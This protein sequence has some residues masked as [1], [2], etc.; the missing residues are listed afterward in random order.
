MAA[1]S[2][3]VPIWVMAIGLVLLGVLLFSVL[4]A[5]RRASSAPPV[6]SVDD[7]AVTRAQAVPQLVLPPVPPPVVALAP[8]AEP[9][10]APVPRYVAPPQPHIVYMPQPTLPVTPPQPTAPVREGSDSAVVLDTGSVTG[11][12]SPD[13]TPRP[14]NTGGDGAFAPNAAPAR[15]TVMHN[16]A[17]T[18][19]QGTLI[20]VVLEAAFDSTRPGPTRA[21]VSR[22]VRGFDGS[23]VLIPRGSRL[24]GDYRAQLQPG[25]NRALITWSRLIRPD[26]VSIAIGSPA[27]DTLGRAGVRGKVNNHFFER[28][29]LAIL[30]TSLDVGANL[31]SRIGNNNNSLVVAL[32]GVGQ[33]LTQPLTQGA[34]IAPTLRVAQGTSISVFVARDLDF[35]SVESGK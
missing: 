30:Q 16:R 1:P 34:P 25:Q 32:P 19:V 6:R 26:G 22:D 3:G 24:F 21:V 11:A 5:R 8:L 10:P 18:V 27:A 23:R 28:F 2:A 7:S 35:T 14:P 4:D 29:G 15:A 13:T 31:A 9:V 12:P 17:T 33:T 20:P